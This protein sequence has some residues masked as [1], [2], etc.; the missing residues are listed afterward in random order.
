MTP[1]FRPVDL[2]HGADGALYVADFYNRIIGH[3]EV[4]LDHPG[5]DRERGR[6]WKIT[7]KGKTNPPKEVDPDVAIGDPLAALKDP[8]PFVRRR[9]LNELQNNPDKASIKAMILLSSVT[10]ENDTHLQHALRLSLREQLKLPGAFD[11]EAILP[12]SFDLIESLAPAVPTAE[13]AE[14]LAGSKLR[15]RHLAHIA[16]YADPAVLDRLIAEL[17][18]DEDERLYAKLEQLEQVQVGLDERGQLDPNPRLLAWAQELASKLLEQRG[19]GKILDWVAKPHPANPTSKS[20]WTHQKRECADGEQATVLSSLRIGEGQVEQRTGVIRSKEF[21]APATLTFWIVGHRGYPDQKAHEKNH[22]SLV[23]REGT[24][25]R[26]AFP[27]RSDIAQKITWEIPASVVGKPVQLVITDGDAGNAYAWLGVARIGGTEAITTD[28]F[29]RADKV[30]E[31]LTKLAQML[32]FTAPVALRD[33]LKP[34]L[35]EPADTVKPEPVNE[36][37]RERL[38]GLIAKQVE[39]YARS[40]G[41]QETRSQEWRTDLQTELCRLPPDWRRGRADRATAG[42]HRHARDR[43]PRRGH[44]RPEPQRR[45]PLLL[46]PLQAEGRHTAQRLHHRRGRRIDSGARCDRRAGANPEI[47]HHITRDYPNVAD[48]GDIRLYLGNQ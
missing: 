7:R 14:V 17:R 32:R 38:D 28:T 23:T 2:C 34:W 1:W 24:G 5:R 45:Q 16:R 33:Q 18:E 21:P 22:V 6:I 37:M 12:M 39:S 47:S 36:A 25:L 15:I 13:A 48:A 35:P 10:P 41:S 43:A 3:Y 19:G 11:R 20:P 29:R 40:Q 26:R 4:P 46:D 8:S 44:H 31:G 27:P 9:A 42:W 30:D